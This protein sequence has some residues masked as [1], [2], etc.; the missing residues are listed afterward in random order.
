MVIKKV[1]RDFLQSLLITTKFRYKEL[2]K[3]F[4]NDISINTGKIKSKKIYLQNSSISKI[5]KKFKNF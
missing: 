1:K 2:N 5:N 4:A 3:M